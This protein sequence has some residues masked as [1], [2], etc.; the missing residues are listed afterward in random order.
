MCVLVHTCG[1]GTLCRVLVH[2]M[3]TCIHDHVCRCIYRVYVNIKGHLHGIAVK[4][5]EY[6]PPSLQQRRHIISTLRYMCTCTSCIHVPLWYM[7]KRERDRAKDKHLTCTFWS[8]LSISSACPYSCAYAPLTIRG[9]ATWR[10]WTWK[11]CNNH[12]TVG[13][14]KKHTRQGWKTIPRLQI[15]PRFACKD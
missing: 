15:V 4:T 7:Y 12:C 10:P 14:C 9:T 3:S 2:T 5:T 6:M 11:K 13:T 1:T 8:A